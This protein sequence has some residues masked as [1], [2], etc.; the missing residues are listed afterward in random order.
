MLKY[1]VPETMKGIVE[2]DKVYELQEEKLNDTE[3]NID[4][5]SKQC[6][7]LSSTKYGLDLWEKFVGIKTDK[8]KEEQFRRESIIAKLRGQGTTT[9]A[10]IKSVAESFSNGE[11]EVKENASNYTFTIK[12]VGNI[13]IPPNLEDLKKSIEEIKPAH[14]AVSYEFKY[15]TYNELIGKTY[16][17]LSAYTH[18]ALREGVI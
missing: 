4:E 7:V 17:G 18:S 5:L 9:V 13:G 8:T 12:F 6:Y 11:V 1:L 14:L 3:Q 15:R 2:L 10:L 16:S